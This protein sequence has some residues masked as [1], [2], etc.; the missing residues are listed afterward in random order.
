MYQ[1]K[2]SDACVSCLDISIAYK[3]FPV[4]YVVQFPR[5]LYCGIRN[6][7]LPEHRPTMPYFFFISVIN[8]LDAQNIVLQ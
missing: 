1:T 7:L 8:Q 4:T 3:I 2:R 6:L 5:T